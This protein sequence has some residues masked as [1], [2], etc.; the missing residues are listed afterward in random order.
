MEMVHAFTMKVIIWAPGPI[1]LLRV[2]ASDNSIL[3]LEDVWSFY[4]YK[5]IISHSVKVVASSCFSM[6]LDVIYCL[7]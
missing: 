3:Y 4:V 7:R 2:N 5:L 1:W 6:V